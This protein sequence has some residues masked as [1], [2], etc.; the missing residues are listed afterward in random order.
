[1]FYLIHVVGDTSVADKADVARR[2]IMNPMAIA[3]IA[4]VSLSCEH[5]PM[6]QVP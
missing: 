1:M 6:P 5:S 4:L 2:Y 3:R